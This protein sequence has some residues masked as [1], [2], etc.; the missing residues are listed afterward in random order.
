MIVAGLWVQAQWQ[1]LWEEVPKAWRQL[2]ER[3]AEREDLRAGPFMDVSLGVVDS[4]YLE[5]VGVRVS[6][7]AQ[8]F[9][10]LKAIRIPAQ[11][12][13]H[14]QHVGPV[15]G[16][17]GTFGAME[18]WARQQGLKLSEFKLDLGYTPAGEETAHDLYVGLQPETAWR[19]LDQGLG[20]VDKPGSGRE[21]NV[22]CLDVVHRP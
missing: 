19:H 2:F 15:T 9:P 22:R 13:L 16:I 17:A 6:E 1:Q 21:V 20:T 10:G 18:A 4:K 3:L 12:L 8:L 14:H 7:E 5:L 11:R